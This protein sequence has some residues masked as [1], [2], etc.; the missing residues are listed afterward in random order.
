MPRNSARHSLFL[1]HRQ[2][3]RSS[4]MLVNFP[5]HAGKEVRPEFVATSSFL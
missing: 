5:G 2:E 3:D 1:C 4:E